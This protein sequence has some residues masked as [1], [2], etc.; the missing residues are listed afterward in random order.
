M[1]ENRERIILKNCRLIP[2]LSGG[3]Q[4]DSASILIENGKIEQIWPRFTSVVTD[5]RE[6]DCGGNTLLPGLIDLHVHICTIGCGT[7]REYVSD[8]DTLYRACENAQKYLDFGFTTVRDMGS[9]SGVACI[10]RNMIRKGM[11]QGPGIITAGQMLMPAGMLETE[12]NNAYRLVSGQEDIKRA[13]REEIGESKADLIKLYA[14]GS[15]YYEGGEP[16]LPIMTREEIRA[17]VEMA[18]FRGKKAAAHCHSAAAVHTC[19]E[20][21]VYTIEHGSFIEDEDILLLQQE[22]S[23][24]VPTLSPYVQNTS[25]NEMLENMAP[26]IKKA[27]EAGL[28]LGFG[29]DMTDGGWAE[30]P[31]A[32]FRMRSELCGMKAIDLLLQAT[33]ISAYIAGIEDSAGEIRQGL[34]ADLILVRGEPEK[35]IRVMCRKPEMVMKNGMIFRMENGGK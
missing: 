3:R 22:Q 11:L 24:L 29:S 1:R 12:Q 27:Y 25:G 31:G 30:N 28:K 20:E 13:V 2:E 18:A 33:K 8:F 9:T 35:D 17:A 6:I 5:A 26:R 4:Y 21:G 16:Q 7:G 14:S 32:E 34:N 19:L 23:Y 10:V 15:A